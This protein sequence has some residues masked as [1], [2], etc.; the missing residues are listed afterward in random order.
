MRTFEE[1][2]SGMRVCQAERA[3]ISDIAGEDIPQD[4]TRHQ[5]PHPKTSHSKRHTTRYTSEKEKTAISPWIRPF[6]CY[7]NKVRVPPNGRDHRGLRSPQKETVPRFRSLRRGHHHATALKLEE[8]REKAGVGGGRGVLS[9]EADLNP[10][11]AGNDAREAGIQTSYFDCC[12]RKP[13]QFQCRAS[14]LQSIFVPLK[15]S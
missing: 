12:R 7:K 9:A 5:R 11:A 3:K 4:H 14:T 2:E 10:I 13:S 6:L 1:Q 8:S 15:P